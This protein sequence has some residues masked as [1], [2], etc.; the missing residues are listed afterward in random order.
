LFDDSANGVAGDGGKPWFQST[1]TYKILTMQGGL[2]RSQHTLSMVSHS[3][4][5]FID[6]QWCAPIL[7]QAA[8]STE[9]LAVR[10]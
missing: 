6:F 1:E 7:W 4:I 8:R 2:L 5:I 10:R 9:L 3:T